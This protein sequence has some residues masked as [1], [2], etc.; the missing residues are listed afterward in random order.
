MM[1]TQL[2]TSVANIIVAVMQAQRLR[3]VPGSSEKRLPGQFGSCGVTSANRD[4]STSPCADSDDMD[5]D[6]IGL[7]DADTLNLML[8]EL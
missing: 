1:A 8:D 6:D 7:I 5:L 3:H 4:G 2:C